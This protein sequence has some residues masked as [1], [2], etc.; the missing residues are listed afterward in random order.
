MIKKYGQFIKEN[1]SLVSDDEIIEFLDKLDKLSKY[2]DETS[3]EGSS[4]D[5]RWEHKDNLIIVNYGWSTYEEGSSKKLLIDL[6]TLDVTYTEDTSSV[7]GNYQNGDKKRFN[8]LEEVYKKYFDE[9][10]IPNY[11]LHDP[12]QMIIGYHYKLTEP[13]YDDFDEGL[14]PEPSIV[15]VISKTK[16]G[17]IL[18]DIEHGFTYERTFQHLMTCEIEKVSE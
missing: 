5:L 17:L 12:H 11:K 13:V 9:Y 15:E 18:M 8:S 2:Y 3:E 1:L 14:E 4:S 6:T 10:I 7:Y 16:D